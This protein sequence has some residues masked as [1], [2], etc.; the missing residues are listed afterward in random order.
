MAANFLREDV[1]TRTA[2]DR[3]QFLKV[4]AVS[5]G[6]ML[7]AF[8]LPLT[9]AKPAAANK[10]ATL[11]AWVRIDPDDTVTVIVPA[12]EMGQGV[13]TS[14]PMILA[15]E[16]EADWRKVRVEAAGVDPVYR[17]AGEFIPEVFTAGSTSIMLGMPRLRQ[18]GAAARDM[19]IRA[20]AQRW[21]VPANECDAE[22]SVVT[23]MPTGRTARYG[24]L[25]AA[26]TQLEPALEPTLKSKE[27][28]KFIGKPMKRLDTRAK[29]TGEAVY[30][31]DVT[32]P[33]MLTATVQTS[34]VHG[35]RVSSYDKAAAMAL[36]G[37][38]DVVEVPSGVAVVADTFWH[39]KTGLDALN[40]TFEADDSERIDDAW[41]QTEYGRAL[42]EP[43]APVGHEVGDAPGA[44]ANAEN[45]LEATYFVPFLAH[46]TME[47]MT[48]TAMVTDDGCDIWAGMQGIELAMREAMKITGLPEDKVRMHNVLLG[49]GFGRRYE[50]DSAI[51]AVTI[52]KALPGQPIKLIWTRE[53]DIQHDFY[54]PAVMTRV[55]AAMGEDGRPIALD[56]RNVGPSVVEHSPAFAGF[57]EPVDFTMVDGWNNLNYAIPNQRM[58]W[59][60]VE[61]HMPIGWWRSVGNSHNGYVKESFI[62][63]LAH[64]ASQDPFEYRRQSCPA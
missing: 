52:A 62:D 22:A 55:R 41:F 38:V 35:G 34:P 30:G 19:L 14:F 25:A 29:I 8:D 7:L 21:D 57:I 20:A 31:I 46:A 5:G 15:D 39:A 36:P 50:P 60:R 12:A 64:V 61:S 2:I 10:Q 56:V 28:F 54:R 9:G 58:D 17:L 33:E 48:C 16:L 44:I 43:D 27:Q 26:A 24:E 3:R 51:Q 23:H 32:L 13:Y 63:E 40:T 11:N 6:A 42:N 37:V 53:E 4:S 47:P 45:V 49:G 59:V 18:A 1:M